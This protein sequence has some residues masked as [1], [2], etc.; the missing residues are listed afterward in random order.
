MLEAEGERGQPRLGKIDRVRLCEL[1]AAASN[2]IYTILGRDL[3]HCEHVGT[4]KLEVRD[5][6]QMCIVRA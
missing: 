3:K 2:T 4:V 1:M 6:S 5:G